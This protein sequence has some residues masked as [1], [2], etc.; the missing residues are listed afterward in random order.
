[1]FKTQNLFLL[2]QKSLN[3][4][5]LH[6]VKSLTF[7]VLM[8]ILL[9]VLK[10]SFWLILVRFVWSFCLDL[11]EGWLKLKELHEIPCHRCVFFTGQHQLKCTVHP[12]KA[13]SIEAIGCLDHEPILL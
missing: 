13:L 4:N 12:H 7:F 11:R 9:F 6:R 2:F 5:N 3:Y 10:L 8:L 1:M